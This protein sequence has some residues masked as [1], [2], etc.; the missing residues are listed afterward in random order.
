LEVDGPD[1]LVALAPALPQ[2]VALTHLRASIGL[3]YPEANTSSVAQGV[4]SAKGAPLQ[5]VPCLQQLCPRLRSLQLDIDFQSHDPEDGGGD[6]KRVDAPVAEVLPD[7]LEQ[8]HITNA[9]LYSDLAVT[10]ATLMRFAA[11]S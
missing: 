7:K 10:C 5:A 11:S 2:L 6:E 9:G 4:F 8:L 1:S 3:I